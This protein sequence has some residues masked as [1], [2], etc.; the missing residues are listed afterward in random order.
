MREARPR[1]ESTGESYASEP[2]RSTTEATRASALRSASA[3]ARASAPSGAGASG[4][5]QARAVD[6]GE[7]TRWC[8]QSPSSSSMT[9]PTSLRRLSLEGN[10]CTER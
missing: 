1:R 2:Q 8:H 3:M 9:A 7:N 10:D 4:L 6:S 5:A